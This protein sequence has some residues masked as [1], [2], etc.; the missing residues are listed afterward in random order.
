MVSAA[1]GLARDVLDD[2]AAVLGGR[3]RRDQ[4]LGAATTYRVGGPAALM[5]DVDSE[6]DLLAVR[7]ALRGREVPV[8]VLGKGSNLLVADAGFAGLV[9]RPG[10]GLGRLAVD[11]GGPDAPG[12]VRAGAS[13]GLPVLA[14]RSVEA[15]LTGLEW[16]VGV[17]GSVGGALRMNAGGHGSD[18]AASLVRFRWLDLAREAGGESGPERLRLG[19]RSSSLAVTEVVVWAEL[20]VRRGRRED[21]RAAI[22]AIVR[23][24]RENQPGGSNAGS[25][26]ANPPGDAAGRLI[27]EAGMKGYRL[28]SAH[29]SERHANF[30]MAD[31]G[32]SA[33]DVWRVMERVRSEVARRCGVVLRDEV[34]LVGFGGTGSGPEPGEP[35]R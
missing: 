7:Q 32:G 6:E 27:E 30:I 20:A 35:R 4:P 5:V 26:F 16:A 31:D 15:G 25:V 33:D 9:V 23:W 14:R 2:V 3:A 10:A 13:L 1:P 34:R 17:P 29:V 11:A 21:G 28:G 22:A 8:L 24:R 18:V 12:R 19:Y